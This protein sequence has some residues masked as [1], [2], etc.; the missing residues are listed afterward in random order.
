[1]LSAA[2]LNVNSKN[3][4]K[5]SFEELYRTAYK[6][7]L[8]KKGDV[9]YD[10]VKNLEKEWLQNQVQK[11]IQSLL[12]P[13][14]VTGALGQSAGATT[15]ERRIAGERLLRG[16]KE[17]WEDHNLTMNMTTDVL[18][19]MVGNMVKSYPVVLKPLTTSRIECI[20]QT[21]NNRQSLWLRQ[22]YFEIMCLEHSK[23]S[24]RCTISLSSAFFSL[25]LW[26]RFRWRG[27]AT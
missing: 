22:C 25:S 10:R 11:K 16:L 13:S 2:L 3:A 21:P 9:L 23:I 18:M 4:S 12:S 17:A 19:Y 14:V 27:K 24:L 20:A 6:L 26:S 5:L 15:N 8:K 1:M 7:V